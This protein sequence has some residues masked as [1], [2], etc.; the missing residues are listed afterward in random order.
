[1]TCTK[2]KVS[3][4]GETISNISQTVFTLL[5]LLKLLQLQ[6]QRSNRLLHVGQVTDIFSEVHMLKKGTT[7]IWESDQ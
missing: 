5:K 7:D 2:V 4:Q 3:H 6:V 1:M